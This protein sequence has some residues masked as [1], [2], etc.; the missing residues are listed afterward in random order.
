MATL[1]DDF[2]TVLP[3]YGDEERIPGLEEEHRSEHCPW[4]DLK[5]L[6]SVGDIAVITK[7]TIALNMNACLDLRKVCGNCKINGTRS[8][9]W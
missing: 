1:R 4:F 6:C 5:V 3:E 9:G 7:G 8:A 2:G